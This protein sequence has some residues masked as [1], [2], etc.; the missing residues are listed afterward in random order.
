MEDKKK[1]KR[2]R[3][4]T[5]EIDSIEKLR[6]K[7]T[8][9]GTLPGTIKTRKAVEG[10]TERTAEGTIEGTRNS[11]DTIDGPKLRQTQISFGKFNIIVKKPSTATPEELREY[12]DEKFK[13]DPKDKTA[14]LMEQSSKNTIL[15]PLKAD[16]HIKIRKTNFV[17]QSVNYNEKTRTRSRKDRKVNRVLSKFIDGTKDSWP[18]KTNIFCWWCAHSF[19]TTPIPCPVRYDDIRDRYEVN[20]VFCSWPCVAA[21]SV[22]EYAS[23]ATVYQFRNSIMD[24]SQGEIEDIKIAPPRFCLKNF[25]G[26]LDIKE[27]RS[28]SKNTIFIST[29]DLSYVN[30]EIVELIN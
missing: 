27:Y 15:E 4:K 11:T 10:S 18:E 26:H 19:E 8:G 23:L 21:H 9:S 25:G 14:K 3:K 1:K 24:I 28:D 29:E 2:V 30:Q 13:I 6:S 16:E 12:Y 7:K 5:C 17:S 20:G 22:S